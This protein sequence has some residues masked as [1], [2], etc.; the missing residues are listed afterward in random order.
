MYA[1]VTNITRI[2]GSSLELGVKMA[3]SVKGLMWF[4]CVNIIG[5]YGLFELILYG[6]TSAK[7]WEKYQGNN[8][9]QFENGSW[10]ITSR[11]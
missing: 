7:G 4:V 5:F 10:K 8:F 1:N 9:K 11:N 3:A 2:A 6:K